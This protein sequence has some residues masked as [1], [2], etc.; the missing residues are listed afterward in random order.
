MLLATGYW[1][2]AWLKIKWLY[3]YMVLKLAVLFNEGHL[4]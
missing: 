3:G 4:E 2:L 1:Q